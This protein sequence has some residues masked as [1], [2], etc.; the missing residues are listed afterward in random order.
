MRNK[1]T[2]AWML[3]DWA[4]QPFHTVIVTF[5]FIPY[6][7]KHIASDAVSGQSL[8]SVMGIISALLVAI[9]APIASVMAEKGGGRK[10]SIWVFSGMFVIACLSFSLSINYLW[11]MLVYVLAYVAIE[12]LE[13]ITNA[14][15]PE[16]GTENDIGKISG[17]AWGFGYMGGIVVLMFYLLIAMP[18]PGKATTLIGLTPLLG[19]DAALSSGPIAAIWYMV[20]M[21]PF[22]LMFKSDPPK[23]KVKQAY[24]TAVSEIKPTI[25]KIMADRPMFWF[26]SSSM[27]FRDALAGLFSFGTI[28]ATSVLNWGL[29][30]IGIFGIILNITGVLGGIIGGYFDK[31]IGGQKVI[32]VSIWGFIIISFCALS[33]NL[34][35]VIFM[36]VSEGSQAPH[37]LF[38]ICGVF[39]GAFAGA[40]QGA[41]RGM[42]SQATKGKLDVGE[43]FGIYGMTGRATAFLAPLSVLLATQI[44]KSSQMGAWPIIGLFIISL[45][46]FRKFERVSKL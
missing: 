43:A 1:K 44:T 46:M 35:H 31:K 8:V 45:I 24:E 34:T 5:I 29:V 9:I 18:A 2:W 27:L 15:L 4:A 42:V 38:F 40:I 36:P 3:F 17:V 21:I 13:V 30:F 26:F 25:R 6:F 33:T 23:M 14:Y 28:Y 16:L 10:R 22:F 37:I 12:L 11:L 41:S 19:E 32:I 7:V 39:I 20:F